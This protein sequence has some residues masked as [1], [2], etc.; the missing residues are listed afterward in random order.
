MGTKLN[1]I[2]ESLFKGAGRVGAKMLGAAAYSLLEQLGGAATEVASH[3]TR[4]RE[5]LHGVGVGR[6]KPPERRRRKR[7]EDDEDE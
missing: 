3:A 2:L 6:P 5:R 7:H 1:P 4:G